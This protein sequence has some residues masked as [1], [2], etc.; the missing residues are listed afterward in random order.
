MSREKILGKERGLEKENSSMKYF[1]WKAVERLSH[2]Q[3]L[4]G[5]ASNRG[6]TAIS[7]GERAP[8][9]K[10]QHRQKGA[11]TASSQHLIDEA[12]KETIGKAREERRI[13]AFSS[14]WIGEE[15]GLGIVA[16]KSVLEQD[17][18]KVR[19]LSLSGWGEYKEKLVP[20]REDEKLRLRN[21]GRSHR[22]LKR[23]KNGGADA[24]AQQSG[25][26]GRRVTDKRRS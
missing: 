25:W 6:S 4:V 13:E 16:S 7:A 8:D 10:A 12:S 3:R 15:K 9:L 26:S 23:K 24:A 19:L 11:E 5:G 17:E 18:K 21:R 1:A 20:R 14:E 2:L 22:Q